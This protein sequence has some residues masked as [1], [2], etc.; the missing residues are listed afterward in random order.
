[1]IQFAFSAAACSQWDVETLAGRARELGYEGVELCPGSGSAGDPAVI[2]PQKARGIFQSTG[3]RVACLAVAVSCTQDKKS[4]AAAADR[5]RRWMDL[6][7]QLECP[8]VKIL[9][10]RIK[11]R[12]SRT[13]AG[14]ALG[15]W[16]APLGELAR[17]RGVVLGVENAISFRTARELWTVL[18]RLNHP[19]IGSAWDVN[20]AAAAGESPW[21]SVPTLNSRIVYATVREGGQGEPVDLRGFLERLRGI[22]Y[23]GW[24]TIHAPADQLAEAIDRLRERGNPD[25][26]KGM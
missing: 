1:M 13:A 11:P 12:Q 25:G 22:G 2:D 18:E 23:G 10:V 21:I 19:S 15:D 4:D 8:R 5:V 14:L 7:A 26:M 3:V 20:N 9:D 17:E 24:V 16:L 6:A